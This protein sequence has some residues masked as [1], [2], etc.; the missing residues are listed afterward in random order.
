M[1]PGLA[2][3]RRMRFALKRAPERLT[4]ALADREV[5][6][7]IRRNTRARRLILRVDS[8]A[9]GPVLTLPNRTSVAQAE[10]FLRKNIG[11]LESR[12][13]RQETAAP[14]VDGAAFPLRGEPCRIEHRVGRG[15]VTLERRDGETVLVV[16]G[17]T[18]HVPR[19]VTDWL[20]REART[21]FEIAVALYAK[22]L[23]TEARGIRIGDAKSRWGSCSAGKTLTFSWRL[24]LAPPHVLNYLA[25]HEAAHLCQMN[26]GPKF[27]ELVRYLMPQHWPAREWLKKN[28]A[29]LHAIGRG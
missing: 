4:V 21:D 18:P 16:P 24:I 11:W 9:G 1:P 10:Q 3:N 23:R 25:A 27:W 2:D 29:G 19:R 22:A 20:K 12:L 26:H 7:A 8:A 14:F 13:A 28:G 5:A 6:V 17:N 15:V